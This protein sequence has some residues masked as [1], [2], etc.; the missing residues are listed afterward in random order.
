MANEV[1]RLGSSDLAVRILRRILRPL[2]RFMLTQGVTY[3]LLTDLLKLIYVQ[4]A[5]EEA[6]VDSGLRAQAI[7]I[8]LDGRVTVDRDELPAAA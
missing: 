2:V 3:P 6:H 8:R 7:E 5:A 1:S 4:V